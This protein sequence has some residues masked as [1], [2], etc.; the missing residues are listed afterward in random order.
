[1]NATTASARCSAHVVTR[2]LVRARPVALDNVRLNAPFPLSRRGAVVAKQ[3][4]M[5]SRAPGGSHRSHRLLRPRMRRGLD[6]P[7]DGGVRGESRTLRTIRDRL[8]YAG[9][10]R[11][12]W[13]IAR[14]RRHGLVV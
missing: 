9:R 5:A 2:G 10:A 6:Y 3:Y 14:P 4:G 13:G 8:G 1:M 7:G 11:V 12:Q